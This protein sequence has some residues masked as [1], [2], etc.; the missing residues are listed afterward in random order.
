M[1]MTEAVLGFCT[2]VICRNLMG[3]E[4]LLWS[5]KD[6][7]YSFYMWTWRIGI[8]IWLISILF[9][10]F[11]EK[12]HK[13]FMLYFR[14]LTIAAEIVILSGANLRM[15]VEFSGGYLDVVPELFLIRTLLAGH[16]AVVYLFICEDY[17]K[18]HISEKN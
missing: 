5:N 15:L 2:L 13:K 7:F 10:I 16:I 4:R 6:D 1:K 3:E 8:L 12:T 14:G 18:R 11:K 17:K 9:W